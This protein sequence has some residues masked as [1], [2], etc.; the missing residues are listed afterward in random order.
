M[1]LTLEAGIGTG[2]WL[3]AFL[4][5]NQFQNLKLAFLVNASLAAAAA[6]YCVVLRYKKEIS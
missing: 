6:V 2:A 5:A 1:Y 3:S 4:F